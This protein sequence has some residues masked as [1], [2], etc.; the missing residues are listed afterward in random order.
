MSTKGFS[1][2]YTV[3]RTSGDDQTAYVVGTLNGDPQWIMCWA[4]KL[5]KAPIGEQLRDMRKIAAA[6]NAAET[7]VGRVAV[8]AA[9][10]GVE[11]LH[12]AVQKP[13]TPLFERMRI[14]GMYTREA[15]QIADDADTT[16]R[17][18]RESLAQAHALAKA[19]SQ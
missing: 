8:F 9:N 18:L 7:G 11:K 1:G 19:R 15:L 13:E 12:R 17:R 14:A 4:T 16:I 5:N 6:L 2:P 3:G 10:G